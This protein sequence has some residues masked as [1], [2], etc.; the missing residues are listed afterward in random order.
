MAQ[1]SISSFKKA[2]LSKSQVKSILIIFRRFDFSSSRSLCLLDRLPTANFTRESSSIWKKGR[3]H[4]HKAP[5]HT[6]FVVLA[7]FGVSMLPQPLSSPNL[8]RCYFYLFPKFTKNLKKHRYG[9]TDAVQQATIR[10]LNRIPIGCFWSAHEEWKPR[11]QRCVK[12]NGEY[13]EKFWKA[14]QNFAVSK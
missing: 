8:G 13:F 5:S 10:H 9:N 12:D 3:P 1:K 6:C 14:V 4:L 2:R 7:R 11:L